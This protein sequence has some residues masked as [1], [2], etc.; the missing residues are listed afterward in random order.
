MDFS[1]FFHLLDAIKLRRDMNRLIIGIVIL[2]CSMKSYAQDTN[3]LNYLPFFFIDNPDGIYK[4]NDIFGN[5][6]KEVSFNNGHVKDQKILSDPITS[7]DTSFCL[8]D[9]MESNL[10]NI[11]K[12]VSYYFQY[13]ESPTHGG[14]SNFS[15]V[16]FLIDT[17][18]TLTNISILRNVENRCDNNWL[19]ELNDTV[20]FEPYVLRGKRYQAEYILQIHDICYCSCVLIEKSIVDDSRR[21]ARR[22]KRVK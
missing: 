15:I 2:C 16:S 13:I 6:Y 14:D 22:K 18:G 19:I 4:I 11:T 1:C 21:I 10:P 8:I 5:P 17:N 20:R 7:P 12:L 3:V 9:K